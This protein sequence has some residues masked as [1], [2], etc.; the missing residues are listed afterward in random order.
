MSA[1]VARAAAAG[2]LPRYTWLRERPMSR[3]LLLNWACPTQNV[4]LSDLGR[5]RAAGGEL[6][7]TLNWRGNCQ[8]G[9][10]V[11]FSMKCQRS[12][13]LQEHVV[14]DEP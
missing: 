1:Y 7:A 5:E 6:A 14:A 11:G 4:A 9:S 10:S 3:G 8:Q 2:R 12:E 13:L